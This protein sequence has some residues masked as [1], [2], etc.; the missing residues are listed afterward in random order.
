MASPLEADLGLARIIRRKVEAGFISVGFGI[1]VNESIA[2]ARAHFA[3]EARRSGGLQ[4]LKHSASSMKPLCHDVQPFYYFALIFWH[5]S[6]N[7][8]SSSCLTLRHISGQRVA[9]TL[10]RKASLAL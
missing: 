5:I 9:Y 8:S 3:L 2:F 1:L 7:Q 6:R 10:T 4:F